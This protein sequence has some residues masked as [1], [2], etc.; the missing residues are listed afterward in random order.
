[1]R[2]ATTKKFLMRENRYAD[3]MTSKKALR[4]LW[5]KRHMIN[6]ENFKLKN[7]FATLK[8]SLD[9][10][11]YLER[12][13][14]ETY[15]KWVDN[16]KIEF[17][18]IYC[19]AQ[20]DNEFF[21]MGMDESI[22]TKHIKFRKQEYTQPLF[23]ARISK[24]F[25]LCEIPITNEIWNALFKK[26]TPNKNHKAPK[27]LQD[28]YYLDIVCFCNDLS[29]IFGLEKYYK[30]VYNGSEPFV[31]LNF[32]A[33]GFRLPTEAEWEYAAKANRN[34]QYPGSDD[35][36]EIGWFDSTGTNWDIEVKGKKPNAWGFYDMMG[37][38]YEL[39]EDLWDGKDE[40]Y[41]KKI[42]NEGIILVDPLCLDVNQK[43]ASHSSIAYRQIKPKE[44]LR[45]ILKGIDLTDPITDIDFTYK[46]ISFRHLIKDNVKSFFFGDIT[47]GISFRIARNGF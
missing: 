33:N 27:G 31:K 41:K 42:R 19:D 43:Q 16:Q 46:D 18:M 5:K 7:M 34:Y 36:L 26:E 2:K 10:S 47:K 14:R 44:H 24:S 4:F 20:D 40:E 12:E 38:C 9:V 21:Y 8:A 30:L 13:T 39:V 29:E 23:K 6:Q 22:R 17:D 28:N 25:W 37:L 1:M 35:P 11:N 3:Q 45:D 15:K 32:N